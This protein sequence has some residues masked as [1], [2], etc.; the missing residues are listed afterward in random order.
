M[1]NILII[2]GLILLA[3]SI[4]LWFIYR[5]RPLKY[6][7]PEVKGTSFTHTSYATTRTS[8]LTVKTGAEDETATM[9]M[10][11][12]DATA[13]MTMQDEDATMPMQAVD[14]TMPMED[15]TVQDPS[16][17]DDATVPMFNK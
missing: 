1:G 16:A 3:S 15:L 11:A 9:T 10:E 7:P 5:A 6:V 2:L 4:I 14:A 13:T 8:N 17:Y 12:E